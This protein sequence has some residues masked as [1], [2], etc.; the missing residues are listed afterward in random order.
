LYVKKKNDSVVIQTLRMV[1]RK[2][3]RRRKDLRGWFV[4]AFW[5]DREEG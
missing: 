3:R 2:E 4:K 5:S 1:G